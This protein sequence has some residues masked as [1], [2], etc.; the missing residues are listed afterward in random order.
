SRIGRQSVVVGAGDVPSIA[1]RIVNNNAV[2]ASDRFINAFL[3]Y[4]PAEHVAA[5]E[6]ASIAA[7]PGSTV[8]RRSDRALL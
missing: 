5:G 3:P 1:I 8:N 4:P 2:A 6:P 7:L